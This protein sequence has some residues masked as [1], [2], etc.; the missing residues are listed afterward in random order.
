MYTLRNLK[1]KSSKFQK[2]K[3][4]CSITL[5][6]ILFTTPYRSMIM[7]IVCN[8]IYKVALLAFCVPYCGFAYINLLHKARVDSRPM[9]SVYMVHTYSE[10]I[11]LNVIYSVCVNRKLFRAYTKIVLMVH[12]DLFSFLCSNNFEPIF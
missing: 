2:K 10:S 12:Q 7:R 8:G 3:F 5:Y 9:F 4:F 1:M 11:I 6:S